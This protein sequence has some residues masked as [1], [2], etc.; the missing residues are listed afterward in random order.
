MISKI[1]KYMTARRLTLTL[2]L[3]LAGMMYLSTL[4]PQTI[5][6]TP[7]KIEAWRRAHGG[8]LWLVDA[9]HLHGIYSQPWFAGIILFAALSLGV[10]SLDQWR[11]A[12]KKL[13]A[14]A[15]GTTEEIA[16]AVSPQKLSSV[17]RSRRYR[18]LPGR[19]AGQ[20]KF[21]RNPWGYFGVWMLHAGVTLVI[22]VSLYV[23]LTARQGVLIMVEGEVRDS[24]QP[25]DASEHGTLSS[26]L[27][28]PGVIRLDRV[29]VGFDS[30]NQP[31]DVVSDISITNRS[32]TVDS[33]TASI[34][35]ISR[36]KGLRIYHSSQYGD[37]FTLTFTDSKGAAHTEKISAQQ[38]VGLEKAGYSSDFSVAWSPYLYAVKYF[39]DADKKSMQSPNP[40]LVVRMLDGEKELART[41]L[42]PGSAGVLGEYRVRL[43]RVEKWA[44]LIFVDIKGMPLVFAGFAIIMLGGLIHYMTPPRELIAV[45]QP[46]GSCRVY[47][48]AVA[49]KEF[50]REECDDIT[51]DLKRETIV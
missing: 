16:E 42:T 3:V 24:R 50:Y 33:F 11:I 41:A 17:A 34:N 8:L 39:A 10:S 40:E 51:R 9:F 28:L 23:S 31:S 37:A 12:R 13:S 29:R 44:K 4:I 27:Q 2:I 25:W 46:D 32:A 43:D 5:D 47:W 19:P 22:A 49:F 48:K 1:T 30:K 21:V 18:P 35:R 6:A 15:I 36:Y 7:G 26:P 20:L 14:T 45:E 38:P